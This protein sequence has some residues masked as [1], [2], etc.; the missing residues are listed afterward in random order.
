M[1]SDLF[2]VTG[3]TGFLGT[4]VTLAFLREGH[5]CALTVSFSSLHQQLI[6]ELGARQR[7]RDCA[8][9]GQG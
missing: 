9:N 4:A 5:R 6:D 1:G 2:L 7:A 8:L 3:V